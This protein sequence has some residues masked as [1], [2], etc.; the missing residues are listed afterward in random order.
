[1][2][3]NS[4]TIIVT[5]ALPYANGPIHLGHLVEYVQSDIWCRYQKMHNHECYHV[6]AD[7]T[8]GTAIMLRA[9]REG[10]TP[11]QLIQT[12]GKEH[13]KDFSGFHIDFSYYHSTHG[14]DNRNLV[15]MIY[16][17]NR[18]K[19]HITRKT[20]SQ[21]YDP[22]AGQFLPDRYIKGECPKCGATD[23]YGD[24]CEACGATYASSEIKKPCFN[25]LWCNSDR[26]RIGT[27]LFQIG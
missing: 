24:N 5:S 7:D 8:H 16:L 11:Y 2:S 3:S 22:E 27:Y 23:Q 10:I 26:K 4:R 25:P 12:I 1:M 13:K 19:G 21:A 18:D 14:P 17:R 6:C 15:E 20:I 9:Q